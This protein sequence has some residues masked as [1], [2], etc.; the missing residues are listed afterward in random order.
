M[1]SLAHSR[2]ASVPAPVS[3][4]SPFLINGNGIKHD[5]DRPSGIPRV[6]FQTDVTPSHADESK[7]RTSP[8]VF[9]SSF[10]FARAAYAVF[11]PHIT[12]VTHWIKAKLRLQR[13]SSSS[14]LQVSHACLFYS[15]N[16][17]MIFTT[18]SVCA[19]RKPLYA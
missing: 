13:L 15:I 17:S 1:R 10:A 9:K 4:Q 3:F 6:R 16:L 2:Q 11:E 14:R 7:M 18:N 5:N 8:D 12:G 19:A